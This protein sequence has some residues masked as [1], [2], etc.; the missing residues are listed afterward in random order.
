V[1]RVAGKP[2]ITADGEGN[3]QLEGQEH[4]ESWQARH[5][6][7]R[8]AGWPKPLDEAAFHGLAGGVVRII[9]P[10]TEADP[11]SVLFQFLVGLGNVVGRNPHFQVEATRHHANL[12]LAVVG[13]TSKARKGTSWGQVDRLFR[14]ADGEAAPDGWSSRIVTGLSSGEGLIWE[15]RDPGGKDANG[16]S[17]QGVSDKRR[18]VVDSEFAATLKMLGREG[19]TLSPVIRN[20]WDSGDLRILTKNKPARATGA[21]ISIIGH[22][23]RDELKRE[24]T[25]TEM[26]NGF[27]NRFLWTCATRS[28]LLPDGGDLRDADLRQPVIGLREAIGSAHNLGEMNWDDEARRLWHALYPELSEAKP[29]MLGAVT[30][31]A[32]AQVIRIACLYAVLDQSSVIRVEHLKAAVAVWDYCEAS[33]RYIFGDAQGDPIADRI[34]EA[35]RGSASG[36]TRTQIRDLF[37]RNGHRTRIDEALRLLDERRLARQVLLKKGQKEVEVWYAR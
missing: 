35:L 5:L 18:V 15:V 19:N 27:A 24:L 2:T 30:A 34:L 32:E 21:H 20:A 33:A 14:L 17:D 25:S 4:S 7:E 12:F 23:T 6:K 36:L 8:P 3:Q 11:T 29:G 10:H 26:C 22:I 9:D 37:Q 1:I 16:E 31:R 28:K 13:D